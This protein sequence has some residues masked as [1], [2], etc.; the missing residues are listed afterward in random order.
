MTQLTA[1]QRAKRCAWA[2]DMWEADQASPE[3]EGLLDTIH[4]LL[5][6]TD[7]DLSADEFIAL[8]NQPEKYPNILDTLFEEYIGRKLIGEAP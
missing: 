1:E 4:V 7:L 5:E 3:W 2:I 8:F 6:R